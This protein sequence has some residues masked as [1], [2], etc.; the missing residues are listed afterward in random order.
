LYNIKNQYYIYILTNKRNGTLYIGVTS[1]LVKR[2]YEHKNNIIDGFTKKYNIHKLAYYEIT[3]DVESAIRREKQ[4]K[5]WNRKW[6]MNLIEK[7]NPEW[8]DLYYELI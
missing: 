8:K 5:K 3:N 6:K 2:A 1:N 7:N 4:L